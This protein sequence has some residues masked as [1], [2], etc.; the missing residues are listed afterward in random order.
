MKFVA[1]V[2]ETAQLGLAEAE[3]KGLTDEVFTELG[4]DEL[5]IEDVTAVVAARWGA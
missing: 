5:T 4:K 1:F 2:N 3:M